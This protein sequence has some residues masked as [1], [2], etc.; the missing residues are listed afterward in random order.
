MT[1]NVLNYELPTELIAQAPNLERSNSRLMVITK[2]SGDI[3][4][5]TFATLV[6]QSILK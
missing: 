6:S 5:T 3:Q 2:S 4:H 1:T